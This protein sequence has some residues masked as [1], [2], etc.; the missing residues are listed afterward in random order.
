MDAKTETAL[1]AS[2]KHWEENVAAATPNEASTQPEDCALCRM[3]AIG[4]QDRCGGCPV[5][6]STGVDSCCN[7][8]YEN[9]DFI[10]KRWHFGAIDGQSAFRDAAQAELDFLRSLLPGESG[11][12]K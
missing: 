5:A 2:I 9:A 12:T 11:E 3:F 7:T 1:R 6:E 4:A 10:L 8:P